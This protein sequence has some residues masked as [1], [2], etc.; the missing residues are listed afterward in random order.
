MQ[1]ILSSMALTEIES[2]DL[3]A[4]RAPRTTH[5]K[6]GQGARCSHTASFYIFKSALKNLCW[7]LA[8][9]Y[10]EEQFLE[11]LLFQ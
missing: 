10:F 5:T 1:I 7:V 3:K 4:N 6:S 11:I 2:Q 8:L 9:K